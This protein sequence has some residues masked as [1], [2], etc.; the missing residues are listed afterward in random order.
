[1]SSLAAAWTLALGF[2]VLVLGIGALAR[3]FL[4]WR[5]EQRLALG[6]QRARADRLSGAAGRR[7]DLPGR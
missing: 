3:R 1:M 5:G 4:A 7:F 2:V 6:F